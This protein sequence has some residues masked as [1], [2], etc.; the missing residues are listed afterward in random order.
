MANTP[1]RA[2]R[3]RRAVKLCAG[4]SCWGRERALAFPSG[5]TCVSST[6]T[7]AF[8]PSGDHQCHKSLLDEHCL[9]L[10]TNKL[11]PM[12]NT[13]RRARRPRRA[14]KPRPRASHPPRPQRG[15]RRTTQVMK[16]TSL[17]VCV[18][19]CMS[20][21]VSCWLAGWLLHAFDL[22]KQNTF[23]HFGVAQGGER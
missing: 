7:N 9:A 6:A 19:V 21:C 1:R 8:W 10:N 12:A 22:A 23:S 3:P 16:L 15:R 11:A 14:G 13:P 20:V 4:L 18:S 2:R 5:F 17:C